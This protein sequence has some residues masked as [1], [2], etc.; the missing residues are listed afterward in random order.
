M[1]TNIAINGMGRI[2]RMVLRIALQNKN[3]NV[4][5][6][7]ASYPPET[8]AHLINYDTT[9]GKYNLKVEPIENGLQVGDHKLNW[10]LIAIL[11]TCHGKN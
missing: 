6:I 8:I 11:K 5:A 9:H 2:G 4:V 1:S 7:N 3:L 10:L